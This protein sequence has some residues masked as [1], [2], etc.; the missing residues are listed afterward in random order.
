M[1][2]DRICVR[3]SFTSDDS[4][5]PCLSTPGF[6]FDTSNRGSGSESSRFQGGRATD[7]ARVARFKKLLANR[8][9]DVGELLLIP[10]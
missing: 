4:G 6:P 8:T 5:E 9:V 7:A 10:S 3:Q 2:T 1:I